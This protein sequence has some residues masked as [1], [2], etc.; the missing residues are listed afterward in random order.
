MTCPVFPR[1]VGRHP[2]E[3]LNTLHPVPSKRVSVVIFAVLEQPRRVFRVDKLRRLGHD[4][5]VPLGPR[6]PSPPLQLEHRTVGPRDLS[7][8]RRVAAERGPQQG[9]VDGVVGDHE[10]SLLVLDGLE[11]ADLLP[12]VVGPCPQISRGVPGGV[13]CERRGV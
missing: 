4:P 7:E 8:V 9:L 10:G 12:G 5:P 11:G 3:L 6:L 13:V 2:Q 1:L